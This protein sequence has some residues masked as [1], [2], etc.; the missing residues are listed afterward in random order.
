MWIVSAGKN[1]STHA[2]TDVLISQTLQFYNCSKKPA[3]KQLFHTLKLHFVEANGSPQWQK[4]TESK[5]TGCNLCPEIQNQSFCFD[6]PLIT[7]TRK[8]HWTLVIFSRVKIFCFNTNSPTTNY[9]YMEN[10][11]LFPFCLSALQVFIS[12]G[13]VLT[14]FVPCFVCVHTFYNS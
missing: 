11:S 6:F 13:L 12:F 3:L 10:L 4:T 2:L 7:Y 9:M 1:Y 14:F 5:Y 8:L